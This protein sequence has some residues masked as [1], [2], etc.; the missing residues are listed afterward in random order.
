MVGAGLKPAPTG[1]EEESVNL[2]V[3]RAR[4]GAGEQFITPSGLEMR[5]RRV[6]LLDLAER[7]KIPAPLAGMVETM[8]ATQQSSLS[9][10]QFGEFASVINLVVMASAVEPAVVLGPDDHALQEGQIRIGELPMSDRLA[11]FNWANEVSM[12]LQPFREE[13]EESVDAA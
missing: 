12:K 3:W 7:G 4:R 1:L 8:L 5:L 10:Q 13:P 6:S 2:A 9:I 11:I